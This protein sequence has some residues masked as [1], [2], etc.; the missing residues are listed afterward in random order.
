MADLNERDELYRPLGLTAPKSRRP[1]PYG[2]LV[3]I[4]G[5]ALVAGLGV[6]LFET[7]D[8]QGGEPYAVAVLDTHPP[9]P[10]ALPAAPA[11]AA[12]AAPAAASATPGSTNQVEMSNGV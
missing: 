6:F 1:T 5:A 2:R 8:R 4:V 12:A 10:P 11:N 9:A 3:L 7:D